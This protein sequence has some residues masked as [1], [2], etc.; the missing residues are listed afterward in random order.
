MLQV[1]ELYKQFDDKWVL[2]D[3]S[4]TSEKKETIVILGP[5]GTG[6]STLLNC[7]ADLTKPTTGEIYLQGAKISDKNHKSNI[8]IL[9][10]V[11]QNFNLFPHLTVLENLIYAPTTL[12]KDSK[13]SLI[14]KA[15]NLL[16]QFFL[17]D[18]E[19]AMPNS[20]S[21]GQKQ[22]VAIAR[23]LMLDP[24]I[25]LFDEPT[26]ALDQEATY[27]LIKILQAL[28]QDV[29]LLIVTHEIFFAKKIADRVLFMDQGQIL[30]DQNAEDFF[31]QPKS[32]RARIFLESEFVASEK[33]TNNTTEQ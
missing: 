3:V 4:F 22:R 11:F 16:S 27:N 17:S 33:L 9:G 32:H 26:S 23:A 30:C 18:K 12:K 5:S 2:K 15:K 31:T 29:C 20:L 25:I 1:K 8:K 24:E 7:I 10:F 6:K 14:E 19:K 21:G 13:K 28:K